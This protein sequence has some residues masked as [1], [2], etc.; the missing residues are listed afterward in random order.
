MGKLQKLLKKLLDE[1]RDANWTYHDAEYTLLKSG[2]IERRGKGSHN[3]F[4]NLQT[5]ESVV[6]SCHGNKNIKP[7][8]IDKIRKALK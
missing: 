6:L 3:V 2:F 4:D 1:G 8:Y 7:I 5:K